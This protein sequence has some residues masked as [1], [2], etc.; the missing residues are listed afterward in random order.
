MHRKSTAGIVLPLLVLVSACSGVRPDRPGFGDEVVY[1]VLVRSF[2]DSNGDRHGDLAGLESRL[3]YLEDL[4]VTTI[5]LL[6]IVESDFYHNYF[7]T[8]FEAIDPEYGTMDDWVSFL[9]AA[10]GRGMKVLMDMETQY[11]A[12]GHPWLDDAWRNP[13]SP[14]SSYVAW[15]DS[16][17]EAPYG[18]FGLDLVSP[19]MRAWPDH[20]AAIAMLN[21]DSPVVRN[22]TAGYFAFWAD[23]NRD[24]RFDD[25]V[26]GYRIDHIMDDLDYRG[27]FTDLYARLWRPASDSARAVNPDLFVVG[28]QADW[29]EMGVDMME[30][31]GA[32]ASFGFPI[33]FAMTGTAVPG[34]GSRRP[35]EPERALDGARIAG[36][37]TGTIRQ[38][39]DDR[40]W[41]TFIENHDTGR[42]ASTVQG[43]EGMIRAAAVLNLTL[44]GIPSIYYGQELGMT[45]WQGSW[46]YDV[47]DIPVREAFPWTADPDADGMAVWYRDTGEWWDQSIYL[48]GTADRIA[49]SEQRP[50]PESL[51]NLYRDLI[52][53]H[54]DREELQTGHFEVIE[55]G[56]VLA[57][58][59]TLDDRSTT[60]VLNLSDTEAT[61]ALDVRGLRTLIG[62][63]PSDGSLTLGPWAFSVLSR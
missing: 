11:V 60:V 45:G 34:L 63:A 48:D 51:F 61:P 49:L 6:P 8:D 18:I 17:N 28:E 10:H 21:L 40:T 13:G 26:D 31:T 16:L 4:G 44:P 3:P 59:R 42:W 57:F 9:R 41:L 62:T 15:K 29:N 30:A 36:A 22:W 46:G 27:V 35:P 50:D 54:R 43:D 5:L 24:G 19:T 58:E 25:G 20:E 12:T 47:N 2:Q 23:P 38:T 32:D 52:R 14:Y 56:R 39:P 1:H 53:L 7:P 55:A 33:R 37:V